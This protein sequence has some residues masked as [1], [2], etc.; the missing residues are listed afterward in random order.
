MAMDLTHE[1]LNA[2]MTTGG[3]HLRGGLLDPSHI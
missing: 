2:Q 1:R 3:G